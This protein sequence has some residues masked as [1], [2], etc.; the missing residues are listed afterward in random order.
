M[1]SPGANYNQNS[2]LQVVAAKT[3]SQRAHPLPARANVA[4]I[5]AT[6]PTPYIEEIYEI[7][8]EEEEDYYYETEEDVV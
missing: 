8:H 2:K 5:P 7:P 4:S 1:H 6:P 3:V